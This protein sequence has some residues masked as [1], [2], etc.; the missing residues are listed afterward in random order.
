M[1]YAMPCNVYVSGTC[2]AYWDGWNLSI[3]FFSAG[4][5]CNNTAQI[6]DVVYH[7][8]GHGITDLQTRPYEPNGAMHEG[9]SDY[10]ACTIT[11]QP[12]VGRGFYSTDPNGYLR[13]LDNNRRY[14][15][16]WNGE[17]HNDG[18]I[19]GGALWHTRNELS[20]Y[21]M[22]YVDSLWH[23]ARYAQAQDF[24]SY[25][26]A[27]LALDDDDNDL[28]NGTPNAWT[29]FHNFGDRHGIGP[30]TA[31]TVTADTLLDSEDTTRTY[32]VT[33]TVNTI[34]AIRPDSIILYYDNG[35]GFQPRIMTQSGSQWQGTIPP[36][37]NDV[38]VNYYILA[39]D[40]AGFRGSWPDG[41]PQEYHSFYVGPDQIPP[42]MG[43]IE[44]PR[45]TINLFGPY[46]P[47]IISAIDVNG[48]NASQ[49]RIHY[50][51]NDE[52]ES[53]LPLSPG[54]N[55]NEYMLSAIDLDRQLASGDT[56][57]FY[58]TARD[59]ARQ[60]NTGRLPQTGTFGCAMVTSE[61]FEYFE[62]NGMDNWTQDGGWVMINNGFYS[63]HAVWYSSPNYPNNANSAFT[64]NYPFD[65]SPYAGARITFYHRGVIRANDSLLVEASNDDGAT[66]YKAGFVTDTAISVY[67]YRESNISPILS[68]S[69]HQ[70]RLRL[71]FV[72]DDSITWAGIFVDDIGLTVLS[73]TGAGEYLEEPT[74]FSLGQNYPNPFNPET[75]IRFSLPSA[76][77]V[78][79]EIF[80]ILGRRVAAL[81]DENLAAGEY[82]IIWNGV[83]KAGLAAA[84]GV[85]FYRLSTEQGTRQAK[86]TLL[87]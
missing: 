37:R 25:F 50:Y 2:N 78:S 69:A 19:I 42:A 7:E 60:P 17:P 70:Y 59:Q 56:I 75:N 23:Y 72:S 28:D 73:S 64:Y 38:H 3:N 52:A 14:P 66:W 46:G 79:L 4:G 12:L 77:H 81:V 36:Q 31:I 55:E 44:G 76:S 48:I 13:N 11:N 6:A 54:V 26:W 41:A 22:G 10:L 61:V 62:R 34:F 21:A 1:D 63:Q 27:F 18:M 83:D 67:S 16:N 30:G 35:S 39:V 20:P 58:F 49:V 15:N 40:M 45:N 57:H 32:T 86:M 85:Y 24:E 84:S 53:S 87:R 80:D 74:E 65:L 71:R 43:I 9:F 47:F 51:V 82:S 8:Y 33:A 5:G 68:P 29:I